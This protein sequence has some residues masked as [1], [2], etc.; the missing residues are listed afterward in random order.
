M[1]NL[2]IIGI[3][4]DGTAGLSEAA[5]TIL[6]SADLLMGESGPL[7]SVSVVT[8]Q[9]TPI[10]IGGDL[11]LAVQTIRSNL[12]K[13]IVVLAAGD[14]LFYGIARY[15]ADELGKEAFDV[16]PH[17]SSMQ[18]AFARVKES[19]DD[20]YLANLASQ[21]IERVVERIRISEKVGD[22]FGC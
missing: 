9:A 17:V 12:D 16:L 10:V 21:P 3:G 4:D 18:L 19:W 15:L 20:A 22:D 13:Q 6:A 2:H 11:E 8:Q 7:S 14:P 5:R 1:S